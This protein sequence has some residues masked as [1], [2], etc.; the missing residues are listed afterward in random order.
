ML[1]LADRVL[2]MREGRLTATL[3]R[4]QAT[5][6]RIIAAATGQAPPDAPTEAPA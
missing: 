4:A 2:V 6:E 5:E 1:P 3:S